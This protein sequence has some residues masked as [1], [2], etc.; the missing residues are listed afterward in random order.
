MQYKSNSPRSHTLS[1]NQFIVVMVMVAVVIWVLGLLVSRA[2]FK[3]ISFNNR[4][5]EQKQVI[6]R[7]LGSNIKTVDSL[8]SAYQ[9]L[10]TLG[11]V[12]KTIVQALP[13]TAD[14][15]AVVS[16]FEALINA[17]GLEFST[18]TLRAA[19]TSSLQGQN[20]ARSLSSV[21][22]P[23]Q[24]I[25]YNVGADGSFPNIIKMLRNLENEITPTRLTEVKI[26]G[27]QQQASAILSIVGFYQAPLT[28][29]PTKETYR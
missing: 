22:T 10:E 20:V 7:T 21:T 28:T 16:R 13:D 24:R 29:N 17:S 26:N 14:L 4:L 9:E 2:V 3:T 5:L 11:P 19:P 8:K 6:D 18:F 23:P 15:P 25:T 12:P 27:T 1:S